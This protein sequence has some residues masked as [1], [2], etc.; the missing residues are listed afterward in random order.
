VPLTFVKTKTPGLQVAHQAGCATLQREGARCRCSPSYRGRRRSPVTGRPEYSPTSKNRSE[1]LTWLA[2]RA[3]G[4]EAVQE[5][6]EAGRSLGSLGEEWLEGVETGSI[7]KRRGKGARATR[8]P[9]SRGT[10]ARGA[11]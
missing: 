1:V 10:G 4:R 8:R 2:A 5:R 11:P 6:V 3:D 7:G 9:P